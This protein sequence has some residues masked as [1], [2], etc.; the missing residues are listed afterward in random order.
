MVKEYNSVNNI[1]Y[2]FFSFEGTAKKFNDLRV[3]TRGKTVVSIASGLGF[4]YFIAILD[5][6][7]V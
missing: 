4:L 7:M 3:N 1:I 5:T 6:V 2:C